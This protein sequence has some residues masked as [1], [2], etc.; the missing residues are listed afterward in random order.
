MKKKWSQEHKLLFYKLKR[1]QV[2]LYTLPYLN[3]AVANKDTFKRV[4]T[5]TA[6]CT[7]SA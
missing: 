2:V 3:S 6:I 7:L 5:M 4:E 1:N